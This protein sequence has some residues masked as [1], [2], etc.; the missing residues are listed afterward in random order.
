MVRM[1]CRP[2]PLLDQRCVTTAAFGQAAQARGVVLTQAGADLLEATGMFAQT[3][4]FER[5]VDQIA[6]TALLGQTALA[7]EQ[8]I[9]AERVAVG[10]PV[11]AAVAWL[12]VVAVVAMVD[13]VVAAVAGR[14]VE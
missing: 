13:T 10:R 6:V 12:A 3:V 7:V 2:Q 5:A 11:V 8:A 14:A 9:S 4:A 1:A